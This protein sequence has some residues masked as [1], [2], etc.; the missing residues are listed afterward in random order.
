[1]PTSVAVL[2]LGIMGQPMARNLLRGGFEVR[3]WNRTPARTSELAREGARPAVSPAAAA[4]GARFTVVMVADPPAL[5]EVLRGESGA[6]AGLAEGSSLINM[7]TQSIDQIE[8]IAAELAARGIDFV[9]APVTGSKGGAIDGTLTIL[10]G[11]QAQ[12]LERARPVLSTVGKTIL[13]VGRPGD[14]T[15]AKLALNLIQSGMLAA[16]AEGLALA[17]GLGLAPATMLQVVESSAGN[18]GLFRFKGPFLL[19]RDFSTNFSLRLM[20][21]DVKL[22]LDEAERLGAPLG[23]GR[24][25]SGLFTEAMTAGMGEEDFLSIARVVE[26]RTGIKIED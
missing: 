21:K 20:D 18:S 15:R 12:A 7:G 5:E 1:M 3:V 13:H 17:K 14:G 11:A 9:D 19:R 10:V 26:K 2:G 4:R 23:V 22:A 6:L 25:V 24:A 8:R 16:W